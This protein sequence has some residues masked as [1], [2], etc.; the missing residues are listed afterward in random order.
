MNNNRI[1]AIIDKEKS[2]AKNKINLTN[3]KKYKFINGKYTKLKLLGTGDIK[4]KFD[5][6]VNS[7][8]KSAREK[9]EKLGGTITIIK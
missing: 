1:Q 8:S 4:E 2:I 6:E 3:L 5:V 9:N 7:I